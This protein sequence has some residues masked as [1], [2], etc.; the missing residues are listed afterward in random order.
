M[1]D[2]IEEGNMGLMK[3]V[4]KYNPKRGYRSSSKPD[5]WANN[6]NRAIEQLMNQYEISDD[7]AGYMY[8]NWK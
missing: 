8:R 3:A 4:E 7:D 2:L 1:M 5:N 6:V